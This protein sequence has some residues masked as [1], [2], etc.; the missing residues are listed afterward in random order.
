LPRELLGSRDVFRRLDTG[1][2][3]LINLEEVLRADAALRKK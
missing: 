3:A 2:E 1:G